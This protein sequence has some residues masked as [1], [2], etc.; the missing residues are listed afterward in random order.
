MAQE[1]VY[2][3][4]LRGIEP[5]ASGYCAVA[6]TAGMSRRLQSQLES[7]SAFS[8]GRQ[9]AFLHVRSA[10]TGSSGNIVGRLCDAGLDY[11][12]RQVYLA[13]QFFLETGELP[14]AGPAWIAERLQYQSKW[15]KEP[16]EFSSPASV[17]R[18]SVAAGLAHTWQQVADDAG[19][20]GHLA[21][22]VQANRTISIIYPAG[23][24][25]LQ[26]F[27]EAVALLPENQRWNATFI[28][29]Y[30]SE[31]FP[32]SVG[33]LWRGIPSSSPEVAK[34]KRRKNV[35]ILDLTKT[36][37]IAPEDAGG[38]VALARGAVEDIQFDEAPAAAPKPARSTGVESYGLRSDP[39]SG[40]AS[41]RA[42]SRR[43]PPLPGSRQIPRGTTSGTSRR[44][45]QPARPRPLQGGYTEPSL[46]NPWLIGSSVG[47]LVLLLAVGAVLYVRGNKSSDEN[48][49]ARE[50]KA[51]GDGQLKPA[52][53][54]H[55]D[56]AASDV[57]KKI[58]ANV[59]TLDEL[60]NSTLKWDGLTVPSPKIQD[61]DLQAQ[62]AQQFF[63][64]RENKL[65]LENVQENDPEEFS[66]LTQEMERATERWKNACAWRD[67][68]IAARQHYLDFE[69][70]K[71]KF[72]KRQQLKPVDLNQIITGIQQATK[73]ELPAPL[74]KE[75]KL[76]E[77]LL[78]TA[79]GCF[80]ETIATCVTMESGKPEA[81]LDLEI[82]AVQIK[83]SEK[84]KIFQVQTPAGV[85]ASVKLIAPHQDDAGSLPAGQLIVSDDPVCHFSFK[86]DP[87]SGQEN[88]L[89]LVAT[90]DER[91]NSDPAVWAVISIEGPMFRRS[92]RLTNPNK[93]QSL[94]LAGNPQF[95]S[96]NLQ[97]QHDGKTLTYDREQFAPSKGYDLQLKKHEPVDLASK[98]MPELPEGLSREEGDPDYENSQ[99]FI[100]RVR[101]TY[102]KDLIQITEPLHK[103]LKVVRLRSN[104]EAEFVDAPKLNTAAIVRAIL[105]ITLSLDDLKLDDQTFRDEL[106]SLK[107]ERNKMLDLP[108]AESASPRVK[109]S[110]KWLKGL[111]KQQEFT[112]QRSIPTDVQQHLKNLSGALDTSIKRIA[113]LA[114]R[115]TLAAIPVETPSGKEEQPMPTVDAW[116]KFRD[117]CVAVVAARSHISN[118]SRYHQLTRIPDEIIKSATWEGRVNIQGIPETL[119]IDPIKSSN[120]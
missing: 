54:G 6:R 114:P 46:I 8:P 48:V 31:L 119:Q 10:A 35:E 68:V 71:K 24:S 116:Q 110:I 80:G 96:L 92:Y 93:E 117:H 99:D 57:G 20:A 74:L 89:Q 113:E 107:T 59:Q 95:S 97:L 105:P 14:T 41:R 25:C 115:I 2:T 106:L 87:D 38:F 109:Q 82:P 64:R 101:E 12:N 18:G 58:M 69:S 47:L 3:S 16:Q 40:N 85:P 27:Q 34:A 67:R 76:S 84:Q 33:C 90:F 65:R 100:R 22:A 111:S 102:Q 15:T 42:P 23:T 36:L 118:L 32:S 120:Q 26:L 52:A 81:L 55:D 9:P 51:S 56:R 79:D 83:H 91:W 112:L 21:A 73:E 44:P 108:F 75:L 37:G 49:A 103:T 53:A 63:G 94:A 39:D 11:S 88:Q 13:H 43:T 78:K 7:M 28:T 29:D 60:T 70:T 5:G 62:E 1:L 104:G 19:W 4:A 17:P 50:E 30:R 77:S 45:P 61:A 66:R 98:I 72:Q 86:S